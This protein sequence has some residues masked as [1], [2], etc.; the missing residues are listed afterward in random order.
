MAKPGSYARSKA[1]EQRLG[2]IRERRRFV[3]LLSLGYA[4]VAS[5]VQLDQPPEVKGCALCNWYCLP[6]AQAML[7]VTLVPAT[8]AAEITGT[9]LESNGLVSAIA[10]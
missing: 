5:V 9:E 3:A 1:R 2:F 8:A 4:A 7:T 10:S 6:K